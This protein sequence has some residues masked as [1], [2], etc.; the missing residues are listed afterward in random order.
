MVNAR[1]ALILAGLA[2]GTWEAVDIFWIS[3]PAVAAVMAVLFF[4]CTIWYWRRDSLWAAVGL[5]VLF[6][7]EGAVA[8]SLKVETVTKVADLALAIV[9][10]ALAAT[11]IVQQRRG[12]ASPAAG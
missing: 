12:S 8:P 9:G 5:L 11:V 4:A 3:T 6:G 10:F 7:F 1:N 2:F